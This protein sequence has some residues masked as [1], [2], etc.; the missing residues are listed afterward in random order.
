MNPNKSIYVDMDDVICET[1]RGFL[2]LLEAEFGRRVE[3]EDVREF[4]LTKSFNMTQDEI[5]EFMERAHQPGFLGALPPMPGAVETIQAWA[6]EGY[7]IEV[8]TG[9]PPS[10]RACSEEWLKRHAVP[11]ANLKFV[12]KY[13]RVEA[14]PQLFRSHDPG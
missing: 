7:E 3:F 8:R 5:E 14:R 12:D 10:T 1:G 9:R 6:A 11:F 2:V 13:G 4:D